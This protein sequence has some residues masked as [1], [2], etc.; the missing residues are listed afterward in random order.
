MPSIA[1]RLETVRRRIREAEKAAN[2]ELGSVTLLAVSKMQPVDALQ[3]AIAAGQ[4]EFGENYLQEA[5]DKQDELADTTD[6]HWHFIGPLQSNKTKP[7]AARFDW[8]HSVDRL[9]LARRLDGQRPEGLPP[10][11]VCLQVNISGESSKAGLSPADTETLAGE[12]LQFE[13]L[14]LRGLMAIP[15]PASD[16]EKQRQPFRALRELLDRLNQRFPLHMD[17]LSMGM[18]ADL[19]AA[20]AEGATIV[21]VGTDVFGPRPDPATTA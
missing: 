5:A 4:R 20:I 19:E 13:R 11:N 3:Q 2:R 15:A 14:R 21:R 10:L 9:K 8:V 1:T 6:L 16:P 12:M 18:S 7:A 17:T